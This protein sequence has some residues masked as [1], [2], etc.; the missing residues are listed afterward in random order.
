MKLSKY[1]SKIKG[2]ETIG[3]SQFVAIFILLIVTCLLLNSCKSKENTSANEPQKEVQEEAEP[4]IA[5]LTEEQI[6]SVGIQFGVI[7]QK[8]LT[9]TLKA[10]GILKVPNNNKANATSLYGGVIKSINVQTGSYVKQG[11]VI[12]TITNPQFIQI[13]EEYLSIASKIIFA[14]QELERQKELNQGNA[15]ALKNYQSADAELKT[16]RTRRASLQEQI[17]LMG[18]NPTNISNTNLYTTLAVKS[19]IGGT[20]SNII[21]KIGSFVDVASPVVEIV[22]NGALHLDLNVFEKDLPMLKVGQIIHFTLTNNAI[23]EYDAKVYSI[24]TAFENETKTIPI[25]ATVQGDKAGL[26]DGM[27]ITAIVSLNNI[28]QPA[29]AND[30]IVSANGKYYIFIVKEE[31]DKESITTFEKIEIA[32]GVSNVG[33]TAITPVHEIPQ[34]AKI[35][36]K[37]AFFINAKLTNKGEE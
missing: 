31:K 9:A 28:T 37:S 6:K 20:V 7:E 32:K 16:M 13:Q 23:N 18:I 1:K 14:E 26:I 17:Q 36:I 22:D 33:F 10:N 11:Q 25:H 29:V 8:E 35:V 24:G 5:S 19:P 12:A 34:G 30:A 27:N 21:A 4:M 3:K 2:Q 15:G